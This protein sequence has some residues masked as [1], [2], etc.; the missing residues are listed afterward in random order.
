MHVVSTF[1]SR[2]SC[3]SIS[4]MVHL[5]DL[6]FN[7]WIECCVQGAPWSHTGEDWSGDVVCVHSPTDN[8]SCCEVCSTNF[9]LK[10]TAIYKN[11]ESYFEQWSQNLGES[12][13]VLFRLRHSQ[14]TKRQSH[15]G[16]LAWTT[17]DGSFHT[18]HT[19]L[20]YLA[21]AVYIYAGLEV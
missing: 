2:H 21:H 6:K 19:D 17:R 11:Q 13:P 12:H 9:K 15:W 5:S 20:A 3:N 18:R 4:H 16:S 10:C 7:S 8:T 1:F 14:L